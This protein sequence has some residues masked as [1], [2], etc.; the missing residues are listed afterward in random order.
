MT[1][2]VCEV[3]ECGA[4]IS[5]GCGTH[6]G[7]AIC[8][9][10]RASLYYWRGK[11]PKALDAR[12]QQLAFLNERTAYLQGHVGRLVRAA[13]QRAASAIQRAREARTH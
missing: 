2:N 6:G 4:E 7:L 5:A 3:P 1:K 9:R 13:K 10:C 8:A 12:R 11:G